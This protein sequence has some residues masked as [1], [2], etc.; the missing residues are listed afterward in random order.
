MVNDSA[1]TIQLLARTSTRSAVFFVHSCVLSLIM[2]G[3]EGLIDP[4]LQGTS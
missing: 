2:I 3:F 1:A 4:S